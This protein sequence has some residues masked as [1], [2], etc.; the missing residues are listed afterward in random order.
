MRVSCLLLTPDPAVEQAIAD[1]FVGFD[2]RLRDD[3]L[4]AL[5]LI[6]RSHF[7]G[8]IVDCDGVERGPEVIL[9]IRRSRSNRNSTVFTIVDRTTS[10]ES[11]N[12]LGSNYVL[13]KPVEQLRLRRY[14]QSAIRKMESEHRRY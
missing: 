6:G 10:L 12:V 3:S 5:D 1:V 11:A 8:F 7:D 9:G 13:H 14:L 4:S 2:L